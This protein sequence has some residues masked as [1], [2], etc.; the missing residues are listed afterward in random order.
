MPAVIC[1]LRGVNVGG[2]NKVKMEALRSL[3]ESL[4]LR[5]AQTYI[6]S[7]NAVFSAVDQNLAGL[8]RRIESAIEKTFGF[9][10]ETILRTV[11]ELRKVVAGN[12][13]ATRPDIEPNKLIVM[14]LGS[15]ADS[16]KIRVSK[17]A[18]EEFHLADRELFIY[19]PD[20][21]GKSKLSITPF[22]QASKAIAFTGRNWKSITKLLEMAEALKD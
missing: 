16:A 10:P 7:G 11:S 17:Q 4:Q 19:Y 5:H 6:Q 13:F 12:P 1:L 3:F 21:Q 20:G 22:D 9:R 15:A 18:N 8:A 14:F 2:N